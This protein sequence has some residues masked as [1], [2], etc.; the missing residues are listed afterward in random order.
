MLSQLMASIRQCE[1]PQENPN[2]VP[3][4][5]VRV[6]TPTSSFPGLVVQRSETMAA[7]IKFPISLSTNPREI[8]SSDYRVMWYSV[9]DLTFAEDLSFFS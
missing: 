4:V 6:N 8:M 7:V 3:G 1:S 9:Q 5:L 2:V